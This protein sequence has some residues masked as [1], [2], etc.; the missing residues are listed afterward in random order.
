M[1]SSYHRRMS[2]DAGLA[3]R[4][5]QPACELEDFLRVS[6]HEAAAVSSTSD[7]QDLLQIATS[8]GRTE[9]YRAGGVLGGSP[10]L[11]A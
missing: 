8:I 3:V 2:A 10:V 9:G 5:P 7:T 1:R 11:A 4:A 6:A